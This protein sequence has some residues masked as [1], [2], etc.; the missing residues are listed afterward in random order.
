MSSDLMNYQLSLIA[1]EL[2]AYCTSIQQLVTSPTFIRGI[3]AVCVI[4]LLV[5]VLNAKRK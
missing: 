3:I 1:K 4:L 2:Q 5:G